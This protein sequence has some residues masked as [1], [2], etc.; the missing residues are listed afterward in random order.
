MTNVPSP[1]QAA[2]SKQA[3]KKAEKKSVEKMAAKSSPF[4]T[5]VG[6]VRKS[7]KG[8][9]VGGIREKTGLEDKQIRTFVYKAK[10]QGKITN[11][12]RGV[13]KGA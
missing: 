13:Y 12:K 4:E 10:R 9:T 2:K 1:K 8:V 7:R 5:V 3:I 6:I 11:V